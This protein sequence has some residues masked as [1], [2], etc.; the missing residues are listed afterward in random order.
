MSFQPFQFISDFL[1]P[2]NIT[3]IFGDME[4]N[5][6]QIGRNI[7]FYGSSFPHLEHADL[8]LLGCNEARGSGKQIN[9]SL[10][11]D[12]V[13]KQ[14]Y[15]LY[16]WH[17]EIK[18]AD[19]GNIMPGETLKDTYAALKA[20]IKEL[21]NYNKRVVIIGG[22]HDVMLAQYGAYADMQEVIDVTCVDAF[23]NLDS[24]S[25]VP[26]DVF[27]VEMLTS[28]PNYIRHYNHIGFQSYFVH[29]AI[30]ETIDKLR[31]DCYRAGLVKEHIEEMEPVIRNSHLFGFDIAAIQNSYAP[32][33]HSTPN[34]L[35]GE[36]A[37][38]LMQ[39][40]GM[41]P[42][43]NTFGIYGYIPEHDVHNITAKQISQMLW[44]LMEGMI[45]C[46]SE[47]PFTDVDN[48]NE[49]KL[50]FSEIETTFRQSKRTGRWWMQVPDGKFIACSYKDYKTACNNEIPERWMRALER[51]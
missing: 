18:L 42:V 49:F 40:V 15:K 4:Y 20:V 19:V 35:T 12:A 13:R 31:F 7:D 24:Q 50:I 39:Y 27:L 10:P 28:E 47:A 48:F 8:I 25:S 51:S 30:L 16:N 38:T 2:I 14:F 37:C 3:A 22:S 34:G 11:A 26:E 17:S 33:N 32:A 5:D 46:K 21:L 6:V 45:K 1:Q 36:E 23:I 44:Y 41:S 43:A 9:H 29:P